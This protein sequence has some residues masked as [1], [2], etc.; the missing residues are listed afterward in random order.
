MLSSSHP[1]NPSKPVHRAF[2]TGRTPGCLEVVLE[3]YLR[4]AA[5]NSPTLKTILRNHIAGEPP[6]KIAM[7]GFLLAF[8]ALS[9]KPPV[10]AKN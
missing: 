9:A 10:E 7:L 5:R 2:L 8:P 3:S 4:C 1:D 6:M